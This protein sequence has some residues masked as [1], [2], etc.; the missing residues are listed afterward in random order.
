MGE[1]PRRGKGMI[2]TLRNL[3][4]PKDFKSLDDAQK[5]NE[6][7]LSALE[8]WNIDVPDRSATTTGLFVTP[9]QYGAKGD[10]VHDDTAAIQAAITA[11]G[12]GAAVF[13]SKVYIISSGLALSTAGSSLVC[14]S[15]NCVISTATDIDAITVSAERVRME[16]IIVQ[17]TGGTSTKAGI[18]LTDGAKLGKYTNCHSKYFLYDWELSSANATGVAYNQ[19]DNLLA[20]NTVLAN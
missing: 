13:G 18:K 11:A 7:L 19:F 8:R 5:Y 20:Y 4:R 15:G 12:D 9:E 2:E 6:D 1:S 14:L 10:G 16:N 3:P 17:Q